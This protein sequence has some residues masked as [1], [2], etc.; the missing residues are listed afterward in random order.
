MLIINSSNIVFAKD[1]PP[2]IETIQKWWSN[3]SLETMTPYEEPIKIK[4]FNNETAYIIPVTIDQ[5]G[6]IASL[7][8]VMVR[9]ALKQVKEVGHPVSS[10]CKVYDLNKDGISEVV[11][12]SGAMA[13]GIIEGSIYIVQFYGWTPVVLHQAEFFGNFGICGPPPEFS[14]E[15]FS[16]SVNFKFTDLND[17]NIDDLVEETIFKEGISTNN[18]HSKKV[19]KKY[20][21]K[22]NVFHKM[23]NN[24]K[25]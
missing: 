11:A 13:Q 17:D 1:Y 14:F 12:D 6:R 25:N 8:T 19:I 21:F 3:Y 22:N 5:R 24:N 4:L 20:I 9:P 10:N 23:E 16:K 2:S 18:L 7:T 15:C